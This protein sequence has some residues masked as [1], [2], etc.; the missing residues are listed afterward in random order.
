MNCTGSIAAYRVSE[1]DALE[2][3]V[4]QAG[5]TGTG[6]T[7]IDAALSGDS[8]YLYTLNA[9]A[10]TI[11]GFAVDSDG[12]LRSTGGVSGLSAGTVGL[13]TW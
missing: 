10:H 8:Q 6:S 4:G 7:P 12:S 1:D 13:A 11:T 2:L 3:L 5:L 9:G